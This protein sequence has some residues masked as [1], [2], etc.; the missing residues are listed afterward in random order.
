[1]CFVLT[2]YLAKMF[3]SHLEKIYIKCD[4]ELSL[5]QFNAKLFFI[6]NKCTIL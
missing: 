2:M 6:L 3:E 5:T 4:F 1:M